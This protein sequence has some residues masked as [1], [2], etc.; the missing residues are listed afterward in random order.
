ML[1]FH[2]LHILILYAILDEQIR[3]KRNVNN[4]CLNKLNTLQF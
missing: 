3:Q 4:D 2:C 1:V